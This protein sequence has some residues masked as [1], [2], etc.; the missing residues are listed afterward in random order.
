[1]RLCPSYFVASICIAV[2]ALSENYS[3]A[4]D[5]APLDK[6]GQEKLAASTSSDK[7]N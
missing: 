1:M 5:S 4:S 6:S 2:C 7:R 3:L